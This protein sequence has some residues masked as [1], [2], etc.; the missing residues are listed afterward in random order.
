MSAL[1]GFR[2]DFY[3]QETIAGKTVLVRFSIWGISP[4][5]AQSEQASMND[6]RLTARV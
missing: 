5:T 2:G 6:A 1:W 4:N 3:D